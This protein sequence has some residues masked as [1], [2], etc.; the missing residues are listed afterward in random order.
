MRRLLALLLAAVSAELAAGR[1][2]TNDQGQTL[3]AEFV[4]LRGTT[5][6]LRDGEGNLVPAPVARL[7]EADQK[8]VD[9]YRDLARSRVWGDAQPPL[10][11]R[12]EAFAEGGVSVA[13]A[14]GVVVVPFKSLAAADWEN[15]EALH[16]HLEREL[17]ATAQSARR[18]AR[19]AEPPADAPEREWVNTQGRKIVARYAG[20]EAG[21]A[22]LW[23]GSKR[24]LVPPSSLSEGDRRWLAQD[25][26]ARL[27]GDLGKTAAMAGELAVAAGAKAAGA[28]PGDGIAGAGPPADGVETI[29]PP[30]TDQAEGP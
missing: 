5:V 18:R 22:V 26:V 19:A 1:T 2:W 8:W 21:K 7:G 20:F 23:V 16:A 9:E 10:R 14:G 27:M 3:E 13:A 6:T 17:P 25:G 29:P 28:V 15:L 11:G 4:R 12:F 30:P 24:F